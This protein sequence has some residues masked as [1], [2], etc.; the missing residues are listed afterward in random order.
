MR[1]KSNDPVLSEETALPFKTTPPKEP[2]PSAM[3]RHPSGVWVWDVFCRV[4]D[5]HG[6]L[7]VCWRLSQALASQGHT[8]RLFVD[9]PEDLSWMAPHWAH[10][11]GHAPTLHGVSVWPWPSVAQDLHALPGPAQVVIEAFGCDLPVVYLTQL[12][13]RLLEEPRA[14][15]AW[16]NVDYLSAEAFYQGIHRLPSPQLF[17]PALGLTKWFYQPGFTPTSGGLLRAHRAALDPPNGAQAQSTTAT[18]T[19]TKTAPETETWVLFCY[20]PP[21]LQ[22]LLTQ[23][24]RRPRP[25]LLQIAPGRAARHTRLVLQEMGVTNHAHDQESFAVGNLTLTFL[26]YLDQAQFDQ[27]LARSDL[28]FVRGE[29]SLVQAIWAQRPFIWQIYPQDDGAHGPKLEAFLQTLQAPESLAQFMRVW[30][31][32]STAALPVLSPALLQEWRD[33]SE[34]HAQRMRGVPDLAQELAVFAQH[35]MDGAHEA[36]QHK[37]S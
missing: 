10:P 18:K 30:N 31:G 2:K 8:V 4:I 34:T 16:I 21:A 17:G 14:R 6:D 22:E 23:L 33:W 32:L 37:R 28:N 20:E 12:G 36:P 1:L 3:E 27:L 26:P 24:S 15:W 29:D 5:N 13:E 19:A 11:N 9:H 7:G 35:I 25:V